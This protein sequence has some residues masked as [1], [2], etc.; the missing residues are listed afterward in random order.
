MNFIAPI[1]FNIS[2]VA[3]KTNN[4][5]LVRRANSRQFRVKNPLLLEMFCLYTFYNLLKAY[6]Q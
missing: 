3:I 1:R 6:E 5:S 2:E 4:K